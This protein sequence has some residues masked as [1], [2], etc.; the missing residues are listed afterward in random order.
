VATGRQTRTRSSF[1]QLPAR[2]HAATR[3]WTLGRF[4]AL[5]AG[6]RPSV[7]RRAEGLG[8]SARSARENAQAL[9]ARGSPGPDDRLQLAVRVQAERPAVAADA[10]E[11]EPAE[12]R[13]VV[14]LRGVD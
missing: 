8:D 10:G 11:L 14:A 4:G 6:K 5:S 1:R 2:H 3:H 12:R 9:T 7:D 13:L